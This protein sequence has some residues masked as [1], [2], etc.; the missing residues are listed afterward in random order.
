MKL[1]IGIVPSIKQNYKDQ[2]SYSIDLN[3]F[4]FLKRYLKIQI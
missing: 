3:W 2:F 4:T 1:K